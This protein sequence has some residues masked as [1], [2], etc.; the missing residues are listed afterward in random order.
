MPEVLTGLDVKRCCGIT[1]FGKRRTR[2]AGVGKAWGAGLAPRENWVA[3]PIDLGGAGLER[4]MVH[5][6]RAAVEGNRPHAKVGDRL[7]PLSGGVLYCAE[8]GRAM[9]CYRAARSGGRYRHYYRCQPGSTLAECPNR[10]SH[11]VEELE[12]C[13]AATF[14]HYIDD[15][16]LLELYDQATEEHERR[17][18]LRG[19][20]EIQAALSKRLELLAVMRRGYSQQQ[21]EGLLTLG[22]LRERLAEIEEE[23]AQITSQLRAIEKAAGEQ[24]EKQA[25]G[26]LIKQL[27]ARSVLAPQG[28]GKA[29]QRVQE[30]RH[31]VHR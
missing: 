21:A 25:A 23:T 8:C 4:G 24:R 29:A 11:R 9:I 16:K 28:A 31:Q 13:A 7:W 5:R 6:A 17:L 20:P 27:I 30:D 26:G 18:G 3:I 2:Y 19:N 10:K 14:E 1:W 22:E 12:D 15:G